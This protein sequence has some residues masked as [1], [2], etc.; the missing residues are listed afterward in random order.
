MEPLG[1]KRQ[2]RQSSKFSQALLG[3]TAA[4]GHRDRTRGVFHLCECAASTAT[5]SCD[6]DFLL[7][8]LLV[9]MTMKTKKYFQSQ[10]KMKKDTVI[11]KN[12]MYF[13]VDIM[14]YMLFMIRAYR[15]FS[16]IFFFYF[17][18]ISSIIFLL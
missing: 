4:N 8:S 9:K 14:V 3:S 11:M 6:Q 7:K 15:K 13:K 1:S 18:Q 12:G 16:K 5:I 17:K 2:K 10:E